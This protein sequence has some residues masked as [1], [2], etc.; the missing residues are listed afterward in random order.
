MLRG[1][2]WGEGVPQWGA[3]RNIWTCGAG[4]QKVIC[5]LS[6]PPPAFTTIPHPCPRLASRVF[7]FPKAGVSCTA[8]GIPTTRHL[9]SKT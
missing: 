8:S 6:R 9:C 5:P 7:R 4:R 3:S 1:E 2:L